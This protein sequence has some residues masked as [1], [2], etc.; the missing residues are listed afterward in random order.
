[1]YEYLEGEVAWRSPA[2]LVLDVNGVGY[3]LA[4][5][6][7][8]RFAGEGRLR[9]WIHLVV[10][11]DAH[12]LFGFPDR[13]TREMFRLLLAVRGVGP[14]VAL[15][16]LSALSREELIAAVA[17][18]DPA[19]FQRARGVGR[20]TAQQ[21]VLDLK[22]RIAAHQAES[23]GPPSGAAPASSRQRL[24]ADA[25]AA[26]VSLGYSEKEARRHVEL[27]A[28]KHAGDDLEALVRN[29]LRG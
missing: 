20:K 2:R 29:A 22:D 4:V 12:L 28:E 7:G 9:A 1:M 11:E 3:D 26:L 16:V 27:A 18:E 25:A 8:A 6:I 23:G 17:A 10:R 24:L 13:R 15:G 14:Q 21:I 5:P 19:P